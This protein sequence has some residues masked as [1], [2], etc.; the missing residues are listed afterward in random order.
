MVYRPRLTSTKIKEWSDTKITLTV[1]FHAIRFKKFP[2]RL[3]SKID[4]LKLPSLLT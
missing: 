2:I 1:D 4:L 3:Y